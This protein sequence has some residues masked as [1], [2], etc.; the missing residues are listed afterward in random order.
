MRAMRCVPLAEEPG[1]FAAVITDE[2]MPG[3]SGTQLASALREQAPDLP[4]LLVSGYG[5]AQ[6]AHRADSAGVRQV[7]SKPLQRAELAR[8]LAR[9]FH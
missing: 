5:G 3:L 7:L 2:S 8:A 1:R 9:L 6:L 4:V